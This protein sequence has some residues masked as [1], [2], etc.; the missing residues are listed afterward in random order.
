[1]IFTLLYRYMIFRFLVDFNQL[2]LKLCKN[3]FFSAANKQIIIIPV[4]QDE[5]STRPAGIDFALRLYEE[6]KFYPGKAR[7]VFDQIC[8]H[9]LL[10]FL[11]K[12]VL[13][14]FFIPLRRIEVTTWENS[15]PAERD[16]G[17][18]KEGFHLIGMKLFTCNR[19]M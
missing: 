9:F 5:I 11:C 15:V 13:I 18:T 10:I 6:I 2:C 3:F 12:H 8:I 16:P 17:S 14:N 4:C 1:M 19:R 7:L